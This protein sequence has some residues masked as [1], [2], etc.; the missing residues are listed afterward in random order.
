MI[1]I[2]EKDSTMQN[3]IESKLKLIQGFAQKMTEA[4]Y[5]IRVFNPAGQDDIGD[6][7]GQLWYFQEWLK[8]ENQQ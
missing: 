4:G 5:L 1:V 3:A 2:C 7:C 6:G 8:R